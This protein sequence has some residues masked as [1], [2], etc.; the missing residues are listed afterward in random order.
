MVVALKRKR[1]RPPS[2]RAASI[3]MRM[4]PG[5]KDKLNKQAKKHGQSLSKEIEARLEASLGRSLEAEGRFESNRDRALDNVTARLEAYEKHRQE[6][7]HSEI[8]AIRLLKTAE[9]IARFW[10]KRCNELQK[11]LDAR[12]LTLSGELELPLGPPS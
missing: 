3:T 4:Q 6:N 7:G 12:A 11:Q 1:G 2:G 9:D 10:E 8:Y 5:L